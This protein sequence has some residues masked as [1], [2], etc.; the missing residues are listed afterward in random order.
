MPERENTMTTGTYINIKRFEIHDGDGMRTTLF[1]KGCPLRCLW[2]HNPEGLSVKPELGFYAHKCTAC[3]RCA[4]ACPTGAHRIEEGVHRF[5]RAKCIACGKCESVCFSDAL[6]FYGKRA[7]AEELLPK[8]LEDKIFYDTSGGG[9]TLSGGEPLLQADFCREL[10]TALHEA[11]VNTAVDTCLAVPEENL[12]KVIDIA[13]TFLVDVKAIDSDLHRRLCG[14]PNE[15]IL[16]N[17]RL[18][19]AAHR[20]VEIRIPFIPGQNAGEIEKIADFLA[21]LSCVVGVRVLPYHN[22]SGTK[23]ESL[24][25]TYPLAAAATPIPTAAEAEAARAVLEAHGLRVLR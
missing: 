12:R 15:R 19:D 21:T 22:L 18:L 3:G 23:Y 25:M 2:C 20:R 6:I 24:D 1:L 17:L 14:L 16:D 9:V 10:L 4:A 11:G 5:D 13:D 8:L 7:T